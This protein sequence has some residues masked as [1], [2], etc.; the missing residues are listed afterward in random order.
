[1]EQL[2]T[3][4]DLNLLPPRASANQAGS[5]HDPSEVA[6]ESQFNDR[7]NPVSTERGPGGFPVLISSGREA[8]SQAQQTAALLATLQLSPDVNQAATDLAE[9][10]PIAPVQVS[11]LNAQRESEEHRPDFLT[12][13]CGLLLGIGLTT[14][15]LYPDLFALVR[16]RLPR[17]TIA[18]PKARK[19]KRSSFR[20][21][22]KWLGI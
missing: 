20:T 18:L 9:V 10:G 12:A 17:R 11:V 4:G 1:M 13:A 15:P 7:A 2:G 5:S 22:R 6:Q 16:T 3:D 19:F 14:G 8:L 21:F